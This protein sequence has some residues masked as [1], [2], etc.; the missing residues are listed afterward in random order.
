MDW[1][2]ELTLSISCSEEF[3]RDGDQLAARM[4]GVA[5]VEGVETFFECFFFAKIE[6]ESGK[7]ESLIERAVWGAVGKTS[8]HGTS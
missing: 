2:L 8:E 1:K 5:K 7:I 6:K 3:L 4:T